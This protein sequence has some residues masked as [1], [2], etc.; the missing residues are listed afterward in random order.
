MQTLLNIGIFHTDD[1]M[2]KVSNSVCTQALVVLGTVTGVSFLPTADPRL[3]DKQT[4]QNVIQHEVQQH[5]CPFR[6]S[7]NKCD[8][9]D[10]I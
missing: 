9:M 10:I 7:E 2:L 8:W 1:A 4:K 6:N 3:M 5:A